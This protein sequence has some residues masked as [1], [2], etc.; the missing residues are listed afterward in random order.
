MVGLELELERM[1]S[2]GGRRNKGG[3]GRESEEKVK[4]EED[5]HIVPCLGYRRCD[6]VLCHIGRIRRL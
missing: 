3:N 4:K 5:L 1:M 6:I 2:G